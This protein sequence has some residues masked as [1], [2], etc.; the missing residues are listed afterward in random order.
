LELE[1]LKRR[2]MAELMKLMK[3]LRTKGG[4]A[5]RKIN[6]P[7]K[8][9]EKIL[10]VEAWRVLN[11]AESQYP[12]ATRQV[13]S[14]LA[15][16]VMTEK[17]KGRISGEQLLWLFRRLGLNVKLETHIRIVEDGKAKT[18]EEKMKET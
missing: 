2:K 18:I 17:L 9:I 12:Y 6:E 7:R 1:L 5:Q 13:E 3:T 10:T 11:A 4:E 16:R 8:V 14:V 15:H